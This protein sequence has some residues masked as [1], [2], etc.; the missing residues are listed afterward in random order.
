LVIGCLNKSL[1]IEKIEISGFKSFANKTILDFKGN[2]KLQNGV[3]CVVGPNG[4]GKSN[5][6]DALRWV[7]GEKSNK[8][9]RGSKKE[10]VIFSGSSSK[11]KMGCAK[12]SVFFDNSQKLF[13]LDYKEVVITRKVYRDGESNYFVNNNK[14]RLLDLVEILAKAGISH[15]N[16]TIVNQGMT[17]QILLSSP[18]ERMSFLED[19]AGVKEFQIKKTQSLRRIKK[20]EDNLEKISSLMRETEPELRVLKTQA[21]K[22]E[23]SQK[24]RDN[25]VEKRKE[26]FAVKLRNV[27][28]KQRKNDLELKRIKNQ[29][30]IGEELI[31]K[32][33]SELQEIGNNSTE[34]QDKIIEKIE[35][36]KRE[37]EKKLRELE[38][39]GFKAEIEA[40]S[41]EEK[42]EQLEDEKE[43]AVDRNYI[44]AK[45]KSFNQELLKL[46]GQ[47]IN[48]LL[49]SK[50]E[51]LL[52]EIEAGKVFKS[53][54]SSEDKELKKA[55]REKK[56]DLVKDL[57]EIKKK[58]QLNADEIDNFQNKVEAKNK[59]IREI[60]QENRKKQ[61]S[62][63]ELKDKIRREQFEI[64]KADKYNQHLEAEKSKLELETK[65]VLRDIESN[66]DFS[67]KELSKV[68]SSKNLDDLKI[69]I[70]KL[71][72]QLEQVK[73]I[74]NSVIEDY[75]EFQ[76]KY[77]FL[78]NESQ[79]LKLTLE[80]L[81]RIAFK[82]EKIIKERM[83]EAF[84]F[85]N[86]EFASYFKLLF[87]GG[88]ASLEKIRIKKGKSLDEDG[89][90][91]DD[92]NEEVNYGLDVKVSPPGKRIGSL[93]MLSGGERTLTSIALLF[94]LISHN[95]PPFVFLDEIEANLDEANAGNFSRILK[96]LANQ[97]QFILATHSREVMRKA[98]ILYGITMNK[99]DGYSKIFS[100]S[101][102]QIGE[103][104]DI[105]KK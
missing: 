60:N 37:L 3:T 85:I 27:E 24:T 41:L 55:S 31:E 90:V 103:K 40:K 48:K 98:D 78:K 87:N 8:N 26:Y 6:S 30:S 102:T 64:E 22:I 84:V 32:L 54:L 100:V 42:I 69:E 51:K 25:L 62:Y 95:P 13:D 104:G 83:K 36:E 44:V 93:N 79:D 58:A 96:K 11:P 99:K 63:L 35:Q 7:I 71:N 12:V 56:K 20:T 68:F 23:K 19:A 101:L 75:K 18:L 52:K 66:S 67:I 34:K 16:Y 2:K 4:S 81:N 76:E 92:E 57:N 86:Q 15:N 29:K 74:D 88:K 43:I 77:D 59:Q 17:D 46:K 33:N 80:E 14:V 65:E 10:D 5:I 21:R 89:E 70:E 73:E 45:L 82:M 1:F 38:R 53:E 50:I 94:A 28:R 47:P 9:L 49:I 105:R 91:S 39:T 72:W 61:E 97:T